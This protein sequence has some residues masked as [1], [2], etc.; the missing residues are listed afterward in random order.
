M[1]LKI[2]KILMLIIS[3]VIITAVCMQESHSDGLSGAIGGGAE[4]LFGK[5][6]SKG[7]DG[8]LHRITSISVFAYFILAI[9]SLFIM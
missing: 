6:K 5:K 9:V 3:V 4:Q 1:L 7:Y 8:I 2:V